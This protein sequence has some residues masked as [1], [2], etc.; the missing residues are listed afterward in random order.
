LQ[1]NGTT[2]TPSPVRVDDLLE[3]LR[4]SFA[5]SYRVDEELSGGGM[6][7]LFCATDLALNRR[8]VI[9]IL[10][11][12]LTSDMMAARFKRESVLTAHLQHPNILPVITA[13]LKDGLLYYVMPFISGESLRERLM[14]DHQL[15]VKDAVTI[16]CEVASALAYAHR[17]GVIHRDIKPE[18]ILLQD[19][20]AILADFGIAGALSVPGED[21]HSRITRTGMSMGTVGYMAPEQ[22]LGGPDVDSRADIY[23]LGV[24]GH[25]MLA[26]APPFTGPST[27][28]I[29]VAHLTEAPPRLDNLRDDVPLPVSRAIEKAL[30]KN[31]ADRFQHANE[32]ADAC[33]QQAPRL[34]TLSRAISVRKLRRLPKGKIAA[35]VLLLAIA[36]AGGWYARQR[37]PVGPQESVVVAIAPFDAPTADLKLWHEGM[38]DLLAR[39]I[40]GAGPLKTISPT[41][42]IRSWKAG[43]SSDR[44]SARQLGQ[45]TNAR[46]AI[47]GSLVPSVADSVRMHFGLVDVR[48][49]TVLVDE[50][51]ADASVEK[52]AG[53]L[54]IKVIDALRD[55]HRLGAL[56]ALSTVGSDSALAVKAFLQGEQYYRRTSWDSALVSY[57]RAISIDT[58]FA[59][60]LRRAGLVTAW[61]KNETDTATRS[62][63]LRAGARNRK[64]AP[65]DSLL[66]TAD[67]L[68]AA[69]EGGDPDLPN[70]PL[71]RRLFAT[72]NEAAARYPDDP[73]VWYVVGE[74]RFHHGYGSIFDISENEV[75]NAFRRSIVLDSAFTPTYIHLV[76][77]GY[78]LDGGPQGR[79]AGREYLSHDPAGQHA[80][81]IRL[82]DVLTGPDAKPAESAR[83]LDRTPSDALFDGWMIVRRWPD[84]AETALR[85]LRAIARKPRT[86]PGFAQDS[87]TVR[88]ILPLE[89]S[90]RGRF[91]E[92]YLAL[93]DRPSRLFAQLALLGAVDPANANRV[94]SQWLRARVPQVH[95]ALSWWAARGDSTSIAS[96]MRAYDSVAANAK[97]DDKSGARYNSAAARAYLLLARRDSAGALEAFASLSDTLCLRCDLDRLTTARLLLS[98][99]RFAEA[100]KILRQRLFSA[101]TPTEIVMALERGRVAEALGQRDNALRSY[102]LVADAWGRGDPEAQ[103]F[104]GYARQRLA[105]LSAAGGPIK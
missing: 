36:L 46:Y 10:P 94:F 71:A 62:L 68:S 86:A 96:L 34:S 67:S 24:V 23:S 8:I 14:R 4:K 39:N 76:E 73:E 60:A 61:Q 53:E 77:L 69:L 41:L 98:A 95:T 7:R 30:R 82:L 84:S 19:G 42:A 50:D 103:A 48:T 66:I 38:V 35:G 9:K 13:G 3:H 70:W 32:F 15:P 90:Y 92:A 91:R 37:T 45:A 87:A 52:L 18:N 1:L 16:L 72:V 49:D 65:R 80:A 83:L 99:R 31:P 5:D 28:A 17:Q 43:T 40:D 88:A 64:L 100:D 2:A 93:G 59:L 78:T 89:L 56:R 63:A 104:V 51:L 11:P 102:K 25:E 20:H 33:S 58:G 101:V 6:S 79:A 105:K 44:S 29:L 55:R 54:T 85:L 74:A 97:P 47:Y 75:R 57:A 21:A 27:Q 12:E 26:G 81:G 22:S